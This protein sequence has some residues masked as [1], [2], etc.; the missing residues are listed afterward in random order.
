[1]R[2]RACSLTYTRSR[3]QDLGIDPDLFEQTDIHLHRPGRFQYRKTQS[4]S[5][6]RNGDGSDF[7]VYAASRAP[8]CRHDRRNY[9]ARTRLAGRRRAR[10]K[11]LAARRLGID[12]VIIPSRNENN[13]HDIPKR[14][15][16]DI[17]F[18]LTDR[19]E[20]VLDVALLPLPPET[21]ASNGHNPE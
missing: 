14:L 18:I 21:P 3:C 17:E 12:I 9:A 2:K 1:M 20:D 13:L 19:M 8:Q 4:I 6:Y 5:R 15:R 16:Q 7:G 10:E 11:A